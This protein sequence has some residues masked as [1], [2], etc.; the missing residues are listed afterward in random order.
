LVQRLTQEITM[1]SSIFSF[2]LNNA[3][4]L[5]L[6]RTALKIGGALLINKYGVDPKSVESIAGAA[7]VASGLLSSLKAHG[8]PSVT[9]IVNAAVQVAVTP[10]AQPP[11]QPAS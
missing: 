1:L 8:M 6:G 11:A 4:L 10:Q 3:S 9:D 2:L 5:S 7:M